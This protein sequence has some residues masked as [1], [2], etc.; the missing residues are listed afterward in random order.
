MKRSIVNLLC[1]FVPSRNARY[2]I[3]KKLV[4]KS[5][6]DKLEA[7]VNMLYFI[8]E[9]CVGASN[10]PKAVGD[11]RITQEKSVNLL[12]FFDDLCAKYDLKYWLD[13]GTLLGAVRHKGFI[14]WD[15]DLDVGMMRSDYEKLFDVLESELKETEYS[16][17]IMKE[18]PRKILLKIISKDGLAQLDIFPYDFYYKNIENEFDR[19]LFYKDLN[20]GYDK[21]LSSFGYGIVNGKINYSSADAED[22]VKKYILE[23]KEVIFKNKPSVF[24]GIEFYHA[25]NNKFFDFD[26]M[27][28]LKKLEFDGIEFSVPNDF[29]KHLRLIYGDYMKIPRETHVHKKLAKM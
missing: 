27:F 19:K 21:Y 10:M 18:K 16:F 11:L 17:L 24:F 25:W 9:N 6:I 14:P 8:L 22:I 23:G 4:R 20:K 1:L 2:K 7:A 5:R 26:D 15:D 28:P 3:R 13:F 29:D 12:K